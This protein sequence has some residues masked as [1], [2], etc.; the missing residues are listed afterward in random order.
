MAGQ[1]H[2]PFDP[3]AVSHADWLHAR[4][5]VVKYQTAIDGVIRFLS[6]LSAEDMNHAQNLFDNHSLET[7][8]DIFEYV[9]RSSE[10]PCKT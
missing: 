5:L 7:V 4:R 8:R 10:D 2:A 6:S 3:T 1:L 9:S